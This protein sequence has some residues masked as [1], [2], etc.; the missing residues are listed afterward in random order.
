VLVGTVAAARYSHQT[1]IIVRIDVDEVLKGSAQDGQRVAV[2]LCG[3]A[4][5]GSTA[6]SVAK[7]MIGNRQ[8]FMLQKSGSSNLFYAFGDLLLPPHMSLNEQITR[9]SEVLGV[10]PQVVLPDNSCEPRPVAERPWSKQASPQ[11]DHL[12]APLAR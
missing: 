2:S 8:L 12:H 9:A 10:T 3:K 7:A 4:I 11:S 1:G 6:D 5:V